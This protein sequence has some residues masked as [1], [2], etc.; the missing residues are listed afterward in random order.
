MHPVLRLLHQ[1]KTKEQ[2]L[3]GKIVSALFHTFWHFSTLFHTLSE[4]FRIFPP[5]L[6]L[7]IKGFYCCFSSK[8]IKRIK[9]YKKKKDQ[10]IFLSSSDFSLNQDIQ[11]HY[12]WPCSWQDHLHDVFSSR[13]LLLRIQN[14]RSIARSREGHQRRHSWARKEKKDVY[15]SGGANYLPNSC[16]SR[17]SGVYLVLGVFRDIWPS[18]KENPSV[19]WHATLSCPSWPQTMQ[20]CISF[21]SRSRCW[22]CLGFFLW[23]CFSGVHPFYSVL[24]KSGAWKFLPCLIKNAVAHTSIYIYIYRGKRETKRETKKESTK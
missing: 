17:F 11:P 21:R 4:F 10:T 16:Q 23:S 9:E 12:S 14:R 24:D 15:M 3:K 22:P 18:N 2:Q 5:G 8:I 6:F 20:I 1:R 19:Y 13:Q 7:R